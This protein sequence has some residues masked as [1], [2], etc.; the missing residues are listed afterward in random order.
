MGNIISEILIMSYIDEHNTWN[1][2]LVSSTFCI[3]FKNSICMFMATLP[4]FVILCIYL[5]NIF[6]AISFFE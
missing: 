5:N 1:Y 4:L 6:N 2:S 3:I